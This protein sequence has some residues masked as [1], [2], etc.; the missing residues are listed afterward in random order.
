MGHSRGLHSSVVKKQNIIS[1]SL[2]F[3]TG[4]PLQKKLDRNRLEP[5]TTVSSI[6][7]KH[8]RR[9]YP[10]AYAG[11]KFKNGYTISFHLVRAGDILLGGPRHVNA[12]L[13]V[14]PHGEVHLGEEGSRLGSR[15]ATASSY[16]TPVPKSKRRRQ[17]RRRYILLSFSLWRVFV[18]RHLGLKAAVHIGGEGP[19]SFRGGTG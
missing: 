4:C 9:T 1:L 6:R 5:F 12:P 11:H 2:A 10:R 15:R 18:R 7:G 8:F 19:A 13:L 14:F 3:R 16:D 17:R